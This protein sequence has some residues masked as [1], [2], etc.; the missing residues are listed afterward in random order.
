MREDNVQDAAEIGATVLLAS[1][2]PNGPAKA[3]LYTGSKTAAQFIKDVEESDMST[4]VENTSAS[5]LASTVAGD[6]VAESMESQ[7]GTT[8]SSINKNLK[9]AAEKAA[10]QTAAKYAN[11]QAGDSNE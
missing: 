4:A 2:A 7:M 6:A 8:D 1:A 11:R 5:V 3:S 10:R 9:S